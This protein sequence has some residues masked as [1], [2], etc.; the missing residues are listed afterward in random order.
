MCK[1]VEMKGCAN[2][3]RDARLVRPPKM[4][5]A[6]APTTVLFA[7]HSPCAD[8]RINVYRLTISMERTH[9]LRL[10]E[11]RLQQKRAWL[12]GSRARCDGVWGAK[13]PFMARRATGMGGPNA[14]PTGVVRPSCAGNGPISSR[15]LPRVRGV[16]QQDR[17]LRRCRSECHRALFGASC[18][19]R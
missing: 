9:G 15:V 13:R 12:A 18:N 17:V 2:A 11:G 10:L 1:M 14:C 8:T 19:C 4:L 7:C 3:C 16:R 5:R 6:F